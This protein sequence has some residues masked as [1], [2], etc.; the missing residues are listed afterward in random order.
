MTAVTYIP[1]YAPPETY[2]NASHTIRSW[3]LTKDHKRIGILYMI[4]ITIMFMVA[5]GAAALIRINLLS[6]TGLLPQPLDYNKAFTV[7]GVLMV[8]WFLVPSVPTVLG[9]FLIP[10]MIGARDLAFPRLNLASWYLFV[11]SAILVLGVVLFGGVDTGWTFYSPYS[12]LFSNTHVTLTIVAIFI[13][14]FSS[15]LTGLNF[16]VTIHKMRAPGMTWF[17]MPL[18]CWSMYATSVIFVL[19]TPVLAIT[20]VLLA[21]ERLLRI[22]IF[23]AALGGDPVLFQHLFW[24]YSHPVVYIQILPTFGVASEVV[25]CFARKRPFGYAAIAFSSLAI[26]LIGFL[27]WA[28]HMFDAGISP[29]SGIVF[30]FLS[31]AV[32]VPTAIKIFSW[33]FTLHKGS[34]ALETPMLYIL[35]FM[36]LFTIGGLTG[37]MLATLGLDMHMHDTY[38]VVAH[39]H[40]VMV[41]GA[42][43]GYMAGIHFWWPKMTGKMFNE[44]WG[45][46]AAAITFIGF[47][48]TFFPQYVMGYLGMPRRYYSYPPE[49]QV[50]HVLSTAGA[51]ILA[52]GY[53]LPL[54]YL[55]W[56]LKYGRDAGPNPYRS[57]SLEWQTESPPP[58]ENFEHTPIISEPPYAYDLQLPMGSSA[59]MKLVEA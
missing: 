18:F 4:S 30:S 22:G 7:H 32:A 10:L 17:R 56:S 1:D 42:V 33:T 47:N 45:K 38:F 23:D 40:Y 2:L 5:A 3:L 16:I 27:V 35:G 9:N 29:Y 51:S 59:A 49:F 43:M 54:V 39:F 57:M 15:I 53:L 8:W 12:S 14:G 11:A 31:F 24:F 36:G 25:T 34:I 46:I 50:Y 37:V 6:P 58:T 41:G 48:L 21:I 44:F 26:A 13:N 28:H 55:L 20:L 19:A 52:F